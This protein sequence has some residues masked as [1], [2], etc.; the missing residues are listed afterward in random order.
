[1]RNCAR[2][3]IDS[4]HLS[5]W[6]MHLT[7]FPT[8]PTHSSHSKTHPPK[9]IF[10]LLLNHINAH[11]SKCM[12]LRNMGLKKLVFW[13]IPYSCIHPIL[14]VQEFQQIIQCHFFCV[15]NGNI[16]V[17]FR[18]HILFVF[19]IIHIVL[20]KDR[21]VMN[22]VRN[23]V[24]MLLTRKGFVFDGKAGMGNAHLDIV[25]NVSRSHGQCSIFEPS[26]K[27]TG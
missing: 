23:I 11:I 21:M 16:L 12:E 7:R 17:C 13:N 6:Y 25:Q 9:H 1:M 24:S 5:L 4:L 19:C 18:W 15:C 26:R 14:N 3:A 22:V 2:L 10:G 20:N 27:S 8:H